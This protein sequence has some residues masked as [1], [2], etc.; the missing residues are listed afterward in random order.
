MEVSIRFKSDTGQAIKLDGTVKNHPRIDEEYY[1]LVKNE[2]KPAV[3]IDFGMVHKIIH[4]P[5]CTEFVTE[6]SSFF[7]TDKTSFGAQE[8]KNIADYGHLRK[9]PNVISICDFQNRKK[10]ET[11]EQKVIRLKESLSEI[12]TMIISLKSKD[13]PKD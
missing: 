12:N 1:M 8:I 4:Y 3:R 2:G 11:F 10:R 6:Q 7:M 13:L 5:N 9:I